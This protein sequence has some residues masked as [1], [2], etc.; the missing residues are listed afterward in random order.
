MA[1][2]W[3]SIEVLDGRFS[4]ERWQDAHGAALVEAAVSNGARDWGWHRQPWG[5]IF[6]VAF[7]DDDAWSVYRHLPAVTAALDA[8]PDPVNGLLVYPGR[9]GSAGS[10]HP[11]RPAPR[12]GAGAAPLPESREPVVVVPDAVSRERFPFAASEPIG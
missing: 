3:W 4:A 2:R 10:S 7:A 5:V 9:G 12:A 6:E 1:E 11:R 8:V